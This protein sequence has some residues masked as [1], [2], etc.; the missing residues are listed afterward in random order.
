MK[1][2]ELVKSYAKKSKLASF[3]SKKNNSMYDLSSLKPM[4]NKKNK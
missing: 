4:K 1:K 2:S 3:L